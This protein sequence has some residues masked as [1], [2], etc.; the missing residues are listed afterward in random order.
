MEGIEMT[1]EAPLSRHTRT[2]FIIY[3]AACVL[4][5]LWFAYDGYINK[6]FIEEHTDEQGNPNGVLV[7]NQKSPPFLFVGAALFT[8]YFLAI[9]GRKV[10]A[11]E[12]ELV[13]AGKETIPYDAIERIDKT[14]FEKKGFFTITYKK[15]GREVDRKLNDRTYDNLGPILDHLIAKIT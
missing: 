13:I 2:N 5:G 3:T 15:D 1:L 14:H 11:G 6:S 12:N 10:V 9:R 7:F 8:G 4:L